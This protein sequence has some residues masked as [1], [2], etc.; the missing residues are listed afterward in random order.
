[1]RRAAVAKLLMIAAL[2]PG[3]PP[4]MYR[5]VVVPSW[6]LLILCL[7]APLIR[8]AMMLRSRRRHRVGHCMAC[9]YDLRATPSRCPEMF[10]PL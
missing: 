3:S 8:G 1:M 2:M 6:A 4:L 10:S 7:I 5:R 9:G